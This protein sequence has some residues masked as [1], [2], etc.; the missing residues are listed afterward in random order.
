[1]ITPHWSRPYREAGWEVTQIDILLGQDILQWDYQQFDRLHFSGILPLS[2]ARLTLY[3][4]QDGG[5]KKTATAQRTYWTR[6]RAEHLKLLT[7]QPGLKFWVIENLIGRIA[8][9]VPELKNTGLLTLTCRIGDPYTKRQ[10]YMP[11]YRHHCC[12]H[13]MLQL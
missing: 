11:H 9:R 3:Q 6:L 4:V 2:P 10:S 12:I 5:H 8:S 13:V 1:M 7:T